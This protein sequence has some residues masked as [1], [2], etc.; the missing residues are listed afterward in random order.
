[1]KRLWTPAGLH[2]VTPHKMV[3]YL[4]IAVRTSN[5]TKVYL[6]MLTK[7]QTGA[8]PWFGHFKNRLKSH[9]HPSQSET[10][11]IRSK[12]ILSHGREGK[13]DVLVRPNHL[14]IH[15]ILPSTL[16]YRLAG[17]YLPHV[18]IKK[19]Y[20]AP[21]T[22]THVSCIKRWAGSLVVSL[23][24]PFYTEEAPNF[25]WGNVDRL[26]QSYPRTIYRV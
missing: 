7:V 1:M 25:L 15:I 23:K 19:G 26:W 12:A 14:G 17:A 3:L 22:D 21:Q 2:G 18:C 13:E 11:S 16:L 4:T 10:S 24:L 20:R 8:H 9:V 6:F 5:H